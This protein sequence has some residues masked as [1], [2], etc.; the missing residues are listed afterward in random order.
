M[1]KM[2]VLGA[3]MALLLS[4]AGH[5][6]VGELRIS[7]SDTL[8]PFFQDALSQYGRG[9]AASFKVSQS[10]KGTGTG[11]RDLCEG[12]ADIGPAS[13]PI[14]PEN[15]RRCQSNGIELL[16]FPLAFDAVVVVANPAL[17]AMG[18]LKLEELKALLHPESSGKVQR[19]SQVR[20]NLPDRPITVVSLDPR[21]GTVAFV[22]QKL[23]GLR[24]FIRSDAKTSADHAEVLRLVAADPGAIGY[25]SLGALAESKAA[26]WRVPVNFGKGPVVP[27][28][29]AM[30]NDSY[31]PLSRLLYVYINKKALVAKDDPTRDF[32]R[33]LFER[34][35]K[36]AQ[37]EGFVPLIERN[38]DDNLRKLEAVA[39]R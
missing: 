39:T 23:H 26:V 34:C 17:A 19:W 32:G 30:L 29:E 10:Y 21:S 12:R 13:T 33:W 7:G 24:G 36:L 38:Y 31:G 25:V 37:Y 20:S 35:G 9:A 5:A 8:E 4:T 28:R 15:A 22:T 3:C 27:S 2:V 16:E 1:K 6:G 18:E 11:F 14:D